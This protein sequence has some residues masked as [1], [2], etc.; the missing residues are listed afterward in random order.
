MYHW[1]CAPGLL[2]V[3]CMQP[4]KVDPNPLALCSSTNFVFV[5]LQ[6]KKRGNNK[7]KKKREKEIHISFLTLVPRLG[8]FLYIAKTMLLP[9]SHQGLHVL[10]SI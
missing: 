10:A 6:P 4:C 7:G 8:A 3:R 2:G 1:L 5:F 9:Y